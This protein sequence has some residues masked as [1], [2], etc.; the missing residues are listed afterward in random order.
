MQR[1][2]ALQHTPVERA[3][4]T[5]NGIKTAHHDDRQALLE[6]MRALQEETSRLHIMTLGWCKC[7]LDRG[8]QCSNPKEPLCSLQSLLNSFIAE[9]SPHAALHMQYQS[10]RISPWTELLQN[11]LLMPC[12]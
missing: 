2:Q 5:A 11:L 3:E 7:F 4:E 8:G 10:F 6:D 12:T 9:A 1:A